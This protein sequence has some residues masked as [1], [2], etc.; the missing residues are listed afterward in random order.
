MTHPESQLQTTSEND[1]WILT[2]DQMIFMM[3]HN[4][5]IVEAFETDDMQVLL[6]LQASQE[7]EAVFGD[8]SFDEAFDRYECM[9]DSDNANL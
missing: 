5:M 3:H 7:F 6:D 8:M 4:N 2:N 1:E 9:L